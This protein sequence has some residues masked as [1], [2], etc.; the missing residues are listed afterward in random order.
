MYRK[1]MKIL[2]LTV[3]LLFFSYGCASIKFKPIYN[4]ESEPVPSFTTGTRPSFDEVEKAILFACRIKG[5]SARIIEKGL[6]EARI[7][8]RSHKAVVDISFTDN[9]YN[10]HYK[11]SENLGYS[12]GKIHRNY[13]KWII[14]L[15]Q[16][17][18]QEL[19]VNVQNY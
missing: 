18:Q 4:I 2:L 11:S 17:I 1:V 6:I 5:W 19:D 7:F 10:I 15:S 9:A 14:L 8:V 16:T 12:D 3:C 13:N